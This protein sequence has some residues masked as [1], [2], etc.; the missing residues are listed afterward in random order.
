M[1]DV[2]KEKHIDQNHHNILGSSLLLVVALLPLLQSNAIS[3]AE[4]V[5]LKITMF[6]VNIGSVA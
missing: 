3:T 2:P 6:L 1:L 4:F 5:L